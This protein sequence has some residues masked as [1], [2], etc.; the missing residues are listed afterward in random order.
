[1]EKM[2]ARLKQKYVSWI[3]SIIKEKGLVVLKRIHVSISLSFVLVLMKNGY[4][5]LKRNSFSNNFGKYE[6][7]GLFF[8]QDSIKKMLEKA[9]SLH[10]G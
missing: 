1:M 10:R 6:T 9:D 5:L 8:K 3:V 2:Q 7:V 4:L